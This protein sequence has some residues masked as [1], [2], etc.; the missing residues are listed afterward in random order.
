MCFSTLILAGYLI[1]LYPNAAHVSN[2]DGPTLHAYTCEHG[3]G[4][5][6]KLSPQGIG[7]L[8]VHYGLTHQD[9][10]W[11][12]SFI[13]QFGAGYVTQPV[14]E[15]Q[16]QINFDLTASF[17]LGYKQ[18]RVAVEYIHQSNAGLG[19]RNAGLDIV[20]VMGGMSF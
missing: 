14:P 2:F 19:D 17:V 15:V 13:P 7:S 5:N 10:D 18:S 12:V 11:S 8:G 9:G 4:A 1:T 6:L 3:L 20:A 16:S